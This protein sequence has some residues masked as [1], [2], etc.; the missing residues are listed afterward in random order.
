MTVTDVERKILKGSGTSVQSVPILITARSV[1]APLSTLTPSWK[2]ELSSRFLSKL[3]LWSGMKRTT[4]KLTVRKFLLMLV[5]NIFSIGEWNSY[6]PWVPCGDKQLNS[7]KGSLAL[8]AD[9]W[10]ISCKISKDAKEIKRPNKMSRKRRRNA[11]WRHKKANILRTKFWKRPSSCPST[12][13]S[14]TSVTN[15]LGP[16]QCSLRKI[17]WISA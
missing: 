7:G 17:S 14:L 1:K 15:G 4:L 9:S 2:F 10:E 12:V 6:Q 11:G 16:T 8:A 5:L 3:S 13:L